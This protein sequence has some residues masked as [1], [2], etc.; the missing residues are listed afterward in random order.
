MA[1]LALHALAVEDTDP[2]LAAAQ[3]APLVELTDEEQAL[4]SD[5]ESR[6]V[7]WIAH[8]QFASRLRSGDDQ[9]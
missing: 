4:L 9:R 8:E 3:R 2:V 5:V 7:R 1:V 6:P